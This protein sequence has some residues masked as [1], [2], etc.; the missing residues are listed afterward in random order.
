M[1]P[2]LL[3]PIGI[4]APS[5]RHGQ[6]C[7]PLDGESF[8]SL[9]HNPA[10]AP[11]QRPQYFEMFG[12]RGLW[13]AGWK[14][15]AYHRPGTPFEADVW[16]LYQLDADFAENHDLASARPD[17]LA[18]LVA[19]WWQEAERCQVLPLDDRFAARFADNG[20]RVQGERQRFVLHA[21]M[22]HLPTDVAPD[23]RGRGYLIE[24][25]V[26]L[27]DAGQHGVLIAHGDATSGY[28][29][30]LQD[31]HLVHDLNIGGVHQ[32][33]RS[34]QPLFS[35]GFKPGRHTLGLRMEQGPL[36]AVPLALGGTV[37]AP[38]YRRATLLVD[39]RPAGTLDSPHGF[40][41]LISWSGLDIGLDRGSA[42]SHYPAPFAFTGWLHRVAVT[43][44]PLLPLDGEALGRAELARQ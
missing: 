3:H 35:D 26:T 15:V 14:A 4:P 5:Q 23:V 25:E 34:E 28:S 40:N 6:P 9:L 41:T 18:A 36:L 7:L 42:V 21:G 2:T 37:Q 38:A 32:V 43:L 12:H 24:A 44:D 33:L 16:E 11:R 30:Y 20:R 17:H 22:G 31:G 29:L 10:A 8:T 1:L 13:Q 39:G 19:L 27:T